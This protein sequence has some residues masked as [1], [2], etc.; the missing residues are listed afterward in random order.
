MTSAV[1][2]NTTITTSIETVAIPVGK[3]EASPFNP[4][5]HFDEDELKRLGESLKNDG[6]LQNCVVR[7]KSAASGGRYELIAGERRW[8]AAKLAKL[9]ELRCVVVEADDARAVELAGLENYQREQLD[10]IEVARW[11]KSMVDSAGYS[12]ASLAKRLG[13]T[14][15]LISQR[16]GLLE[17]PE[18]W[19]RWIITGVI[20][21]TWARE[22]IPWAK[23]P[24]VLETLAIE[25][26]GK[27]PPENT[28]EFRGALD[29]AI[30]HC[31]RP[32]SGWYQYRDKSGHPHS[33]EVSFKA[34][35]GK[36]REQLDIEEI[37][38]DDWR[39]K[40]K[41]QRAFN[42]ELWEQLQSEGEQRRAKRQSDQQA[43]LEQTAAGSSGRIKA[44]KQ[45]TAL[46]Q[47]NKRLYRWK[48]QWLQKQIAAKIPEIE[49][50]LLF[51]LLLH[52]TVADD[53]SRS[54]EDLFKSICKA[55]GVKPS[56]VNRGY[57]RHTLK[58][59]VA[60]D[61]VAL[62]PVAVDLVQGWV[63]LDVEYCR[64]HM[65][66]ED[67]ESLAAA[68]GVDI[69]RDWKLTAEYLE[70]H[71]KDQLFALAREWDLSFPAKTRGDLIKGIIKANPGDCPSELLKIK[72][73]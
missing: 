38:V 50:W 69:G 32:I 65:T 25:V 18:R 58:S 42:I 5:T 70:L 43:K 27:Y 22:L 11:F 31:S 62:R 72:G 46:K 34:S 15:G 53:A 71:T 44:A 37:K 20:P 12:Q 4:R 16:L 6:Q 13:V 8:R 36:R 47:F 49:D 41:V 67:V 17:L 21:P 39:G 60:L 9:S 3:I 68:I 55:G 23:R 29:N 33:G 48:I 56:K 28:S 61:D 40:R 63:Q 35:S 24:M 19:Q 59:L 1:I 26:E 64:A 52:F 45:K 73:S 30:E 10:A 7:A 54:A 51:R 14:Q 2:D 66:A 57:R